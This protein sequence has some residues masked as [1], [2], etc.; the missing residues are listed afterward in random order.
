MFAYT[1]C[2]FKR[3][4]RFYT[5][6]TNVGWSLAMSAGEFLQTNSLSDDEW[7]RRGRGLRLV[8]SFRWQFVARLLGVIHS[9]RQRL[10]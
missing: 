3:N 5:T 2:L 4:V 8:R 1:K 6:E 9:R 7:S 10:K